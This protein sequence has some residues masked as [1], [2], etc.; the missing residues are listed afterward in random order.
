MREDLLNRVYA[1]GL[2]A[3]FKG[4]LLDIRARR[5]YACGEP[6]LPPAAFVTLTGASSPQARCAR[7]VGRIFYG[8]GW[9][10]KNAYIAAVS[11]GPAGSE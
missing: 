3:P 2:D 9:F 10:T 4:C 7:R 5:P 8:L 1:V 11:S 6:K